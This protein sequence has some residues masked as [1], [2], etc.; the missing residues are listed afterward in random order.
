[1]LQSKFKWNCGNILDQNL[2]YLL[3]KVRYVMFVG[4]NTFLQFEINLKI[5]NIWL[6]NGKFSALDTNVIVCV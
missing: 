5:G 2:I 1:M 3:C 6:I 4:N